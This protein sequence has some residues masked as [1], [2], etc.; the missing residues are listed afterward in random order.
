MTS[1]WSTEL[2]PHGQQAHARLGAS[3]EI[4]DDQAFPRLGHVEG[5]HA[6]LQFAALLADAIDFP[7]YAG[8]CETRLLLQS[9]PAGP[10][11]ASF[12]NS[13]IFSA[14]GAN[15]M[16]VVLTQMPVFVSSKS[17]VK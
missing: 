1:I 5:C 15:H 10:S 11:M 14:F 16:V 7:A 13:T 12:L 4:L 9:G 17:V 6:Q 3:L 2:E 8:A